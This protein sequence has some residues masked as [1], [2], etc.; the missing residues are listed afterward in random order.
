MRDFI[1][2]LEDWIMSIV[3]VVMIPFCF[4][5]GIVALIFIIIIGY[6]IMQQ[7][8]QPRNILLKKTNWVC[9]KTKPEPQIHYIYSGETVVPQTIM[10]DV[11]IE[12][13]RNN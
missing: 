13:K 11:C 8:N 12:W 3:S 4:I 1:E 2:N 9:S 7:C 10:N 6:S 5:V